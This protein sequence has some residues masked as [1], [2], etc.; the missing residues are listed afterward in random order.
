MQA[1]EY[2]LR[3]L[4][5]EFAT[6]TKNENLFI[7]KKNYISFTRLPEMKLLY[8][9]FQF[10][11]LSHGNDKN[12]LGYFLDTLHIRIG[13]IIYNHQDEIRCVRGTL[14]LLS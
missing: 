7:K 3:H 9:F 13:N 8:L 14:H 12:L 4:V 6:I 11:C 10:F 5:H 1:I 2:I